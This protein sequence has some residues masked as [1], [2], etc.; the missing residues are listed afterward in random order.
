[1]RFRVAL[2]LAV[3]FAFACQQETTEQVTTIEEDLAIDVAAEQALLSQFIASYIETYNL[4]DVTALSNLWT[5]DGIWFPP[6]GPRVQ[7][8]DALVQDMTEFL[9]E[10]PDPL[11]D[12]KA[13][14]FNISEAGDMATGYGTY[15]VSGTASD[16]TEI[17]IFNQWVA[18]YRKIDGE[19]QVSGVMA[20]G[21]GPAMEAANP[22]A[23]NPCA[24]S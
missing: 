12:I 1:M 8:R 17:A 13:E 20:N 15:T 19:W 23:A 21:G 24:G 18:A 4:H 10:V 16:G 9:A 7:G 3:A 11:I 5:E 14:E 22:C 2:P 6:G